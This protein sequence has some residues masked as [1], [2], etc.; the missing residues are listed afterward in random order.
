M[1]VLKFFLQ[2]SRLQNFNAHIWEDGN[3]CKISRAAWKNFSYK[4]LMGHILF[5]LQTILHNLS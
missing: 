5:H 4:L 2:T 3:G 1:Y